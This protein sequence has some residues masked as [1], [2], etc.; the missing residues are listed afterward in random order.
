MER[1][2]LKLIGH[3]LRNYF[4]VNIFEG[5]ILGKKGRGRPRKTYFEDVRN[6]VGCKDYKEVK[7]IAGLREEW[8]QRQGLAFSR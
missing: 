6:L 2:K 4:L 3:I 5:K 1:K 8:L 7:R